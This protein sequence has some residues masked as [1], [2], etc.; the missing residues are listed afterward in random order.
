MMMFYRNIKQWPHHSIA[1]NL[2]QAQLELMQMDE[3]KGTRLLEE[4]EDRWDEIRHGEDNVDAFFPDGKN[5]LDWWK[6]CRLEQID[7]A[8]SHLWAPFTLMGYGGLR[9]GA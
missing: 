1:E 6:N 7:W 8:S 2:R 9:F 4:I 5:F 3:K